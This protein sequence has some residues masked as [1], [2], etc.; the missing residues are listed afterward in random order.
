MKKLAWLLCSVS[1]LTACTTA[2]TVQVA[3]AC[4]RLP[5]IETLPQGVLELSFIEQMRSFLSGSLPVPTPSDYSLQPAKLP[6]AKP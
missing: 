6:T 1:L 2:P 4:P 3:Q 5:E